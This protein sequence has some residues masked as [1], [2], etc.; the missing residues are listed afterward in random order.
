MKNNNK[1]WSNQEDNFL[2]QQMSLGLA[3]K[4]IYERYGEMIGRTEH[5][6]ANRI[7]Y[8]KKPVSERVK[9]EKQ[10][11]SDNEL[12]DSIERVCNRLDTIIRALGDIEQKVQENTQAI[13]SLEER[14]DQ[15]CNAYTKALYEIKTSVVENTGNTKVIKNVAS[16]ASHKMR[17]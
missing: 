9:E 14:N 2:L 13:A 1:F 6:I 16:R 10:L 3:A 12:V 4:Q 17:W 8:L 15:Q 11:N 7:S 5:A